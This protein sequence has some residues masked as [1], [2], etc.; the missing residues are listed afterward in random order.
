MFIVGRAKGKSKLSRLV[1]AAGIPHPRVFCAKSAEAL[2]RKRV[3]ILRSAKESKRVRKSVKRKELSK[4][5][6]SEPRVPKGELLVHTAALFARVANT[7]LTGYGTWK[8][9]RRM[10]TALFVSLVRRQLG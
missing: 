9:V 8:S 4:V 2:E 1:R 6:S 5:A 3:E 10:E 7:G